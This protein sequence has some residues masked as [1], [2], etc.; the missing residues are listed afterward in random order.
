MK[1]GVSAIVIAHNQVNLLKKCLASLDWV[2]EIIVI[3]LESTD[4]I[5]GLA[6]KFKASYHRLPRVEIVE[7]VRQKTLAYANYEYILFL[8]PDETIPQSLAAS[9]QKQVSGNK[10]DY[11]SIP[12][13]NF[14]FGSW[15]RHSRWWP[16]YQVRLFKAGSAKWPAELHAR[17]ELSGQEYRFPSEP[18][19]AI[20]HQNYL[21]LDEWFDKNRRY[22]K[23][24]ANARLTAGNAF[25]SLI[26]MKLS[27][28]EFMSRFFAGEGYRDGM[29]G[30]ILS[31]LQSFYYFLV[32]AYYWEGKKYGELETPEKIK[33]FPRTWYGHA[34]SETLFWHKVKSPLK[35]IKAKLVRRMIA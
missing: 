12:R 16:D 34:L 2:N 32:Y 6:S 26:A 7:Q 9:L 14:V 33:E 29:R 23:A 22:A 35:T 21:D 3:D 4:D 27:V 15:M 28:S 17:A 31:I 10:Y 18:E 11:F 20:T 19:Y 25:T 30:L 8:D 1:K 5:I 13:Q 24:D